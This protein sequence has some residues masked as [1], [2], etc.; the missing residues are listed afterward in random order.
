MM[1]HHATLLVA[2]A[3]LL[4]LLASCGEDGATK[5]TPT[6]FAKTVAVLTVALDYSAASHSDFPL[7]DPT[8]LQDNLVLAAGDAALRPF[9]DGT[10]ILN[11]G[12][13]S[14]LLFLD[15]GA[16]VRNQVSLGGCNPH[17][18]LELDDGRALVTC[19]DGTRLLL[20][21][22]S[23]SVVEQGPDL[24]S[25]ADADGTPDIDQLARL[26]DRIYVT[27]QRLDRGAG[28]VPA[29]NGL[30]AVLGPDLT[31]L[32]ADPVTP[33]LQAFELACKNPNSRLIARGSALFVA[34]GGAFGA[35]ESVVLQFSPQTGASQILATEASLG[36]P[37]TAPGGFRLDAN[38]S[39]LVMVAVPDALAPVEMR[40]VR[41]ASGQAQTLYASP[42]FTLAG[43][44][45]DPQGRMYVANRS[46]DVTAGVWILDSEG[47]ALQQVATALPPFEIELF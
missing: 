34:C 30:L 23:T 16:Q 5:T 7:S 28:Y 3:T 13:S 19:Y 1:R 41:L 14:N 24:S 21:D 8:E 31:L 18:A 20:V 40:L 10:V 38:G 46:R 12:A 15:G 37:V 39:P 9:A 43:L 27:M 47:H 4:P 33:G 32:D 26:G 44:A 36:G 35:G 45:I 17:D 22:P 6:A 42:K 2:L 29:G 11:R 25:F